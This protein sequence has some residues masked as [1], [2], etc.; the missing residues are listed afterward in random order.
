VRVSGSER[1][2][3]LVDAAHKEPAWMVLLAP[4]TADVRFVKSA[5]YEERIVL[6]LYDGTSLEYDAEGKL[7][8]RPP[9]P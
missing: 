1:Q 9:N 3:V 7:V 6:A 5:G 2:A 8:S 4:H